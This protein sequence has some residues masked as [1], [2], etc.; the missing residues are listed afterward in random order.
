MA[1]RH[2]MT[3]EAIERDFTHEGWFYTCPVYARTEPEMTLITKN[4]VPNFWLEFNASV[5]NLVNSIGLAL[6]PDFEPRP[7]SVQLRLLEK[8]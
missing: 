3:R 1:V 2:R 7:F 5:H 4:W 6:I 8:E